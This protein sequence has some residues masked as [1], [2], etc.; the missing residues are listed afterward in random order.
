LG[1]II[2]ARGFRRQITFSTKPVE[3]SMKFRENDICFA[4]LLLRLMLGI[5]FFFAGLM[6]ILDYSTII[7]YFQSS[8]AETWLPGFM[9][10]I[11]AYTVPFAE[12]IL[13]ILLFFGLLTRPALY[14]SG[15]LLVLLNFGLI[16]RG[17]GDIAKANIPY[18]VIIALD[19]ILLNYNKYSLDHML[20]GMS[21]DFEE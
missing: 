13:G 11:F 4:F 21:S 10:T 6:K 20:F 9:V 5:V 16:I 3:D 19:I 14:L 15:L 2:V 17:D 7:E 8:F 18:L 1:T 12:A